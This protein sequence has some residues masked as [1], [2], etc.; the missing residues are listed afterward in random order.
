MRVYHSATA[1]R[2]FIYGTESGIRTRKALRP[3]VFETGAYTI[4][5]SRHEPIGAGR[6]RPAPRTDSAHQC[7]LPVS[8][9]ATVQK[10]GVQE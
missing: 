9:D 4:P 3:P 8:A 1:A 2:V 10:V 7:M 5:P 6:E